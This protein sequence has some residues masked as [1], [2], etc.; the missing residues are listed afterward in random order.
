[1]HF[2]SGTYGP[3]TDDFTQA[4][5]M[6]FC[7]L[8]ERSEC[9]LQ[10]SP[11]YNQCNGMKYQSFKLHGYLNPVSTSSSY[12]TS[13]SVC[14]IPL[15]YN[16]WNQLIRTESYTYYHNNDS[17][18]LNFQ[19]NTFNVIIN[20]INIH[21]LENV[22]ILWTVKLVLGCQR[23]TEHFDEHDTWIYRSN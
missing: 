6:E 10:S 13:P 1:M 23:W 17:E 2:S 11:V 4:W 16:S 18:F 8:S 15:L 12:K 3:Q 14:V 9:L 21:I 22:Q 5:R 20:Y 7:R 19:Y